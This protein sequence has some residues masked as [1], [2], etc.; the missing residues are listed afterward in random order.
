MKFLDKLFKRYDATDDIKE[1]YGVM[2]LDELTDLGF[3]VNSLLPGQLN[4]PALNKSGTMDDPYEEN[5]IPPVGWDKWCSWAADQGKIAHNIE[6]LAKNAMS[7]E[8]VG[9]KEDERKHWRV[10]SRRLH[11]HM[12]MILFFQDWLTLGR[13]FIQPVYNRPY[14]ARRREIQKL[15][16]MDP[17]KIKV[18]WDDYTTV[19]EFNE[20]IKNTPWRKYA[21]KAGRQGTPGTNIIGYVQNW[22]NRHDDREDNKAIF[23]APDELIYIPRYP[24]PTA[25]DGMSLLRQNHRDIKHK[26]II[27]NAQAIMAH[28]HVD[29]KLVFYVPEKWWAKRRKVIDAIKYGL[30][31][32]MEIFAPTGFEIKPL[33]LQNNGQAVANAQEHIETQVSSGMGVADSFTQSKSSNR[34][35]GEIQLVMF[36]RNLTPERKLFAEIF[37]DRFIIPYLKEQ[38]YPG[39]IQFKWDDLTPDDIIE[40]GRILVPLVPYMTKSMVQRFFD[41]MGIPPEDAEMDDLMK[42]LEKFVPPRND[43]DAPRDPSTGHPDIKKPI[44]DR[45]EEDDEEE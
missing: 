34:S 2:S 7:F 18:I 12:Q 40:K 11:L 39:T 3:D 14:G 20:W 1:Q 33:E 31:R 28:R 43:R 26:L 4:Y 22:D 27:G 15:Q 5:Y 19:T 21:H 25:K 30:R 24:K 23:F 16:R 6:I 10:V 35:V 29:P 8:W 32:G 42:R 45:D 9:E 38:G 17:S 41:K 13:T 37:E 44:K 36:E